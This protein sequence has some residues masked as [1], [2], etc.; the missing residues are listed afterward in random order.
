M[1]VKSFSQERLGLSTDVAVVQDGPPPLSK[2]E[3]RQP[4]D[5]TLDS[6]G[7]LSDCM[8]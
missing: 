6:G 8:H 1:G 5:G 2:A 7:F 3:S 4:S